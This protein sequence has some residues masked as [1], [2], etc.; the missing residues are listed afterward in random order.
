MDVIEQMAL[1]TKIAKVFTPSAPIDN[2]QLFAGRT[3]QLLKVVNAVSRRGQ[4][5][6]LYG[7]RGVGKTSLANILFEALENM[8]AGD[9][10]VKAVNCEA[11]ITFSSL[12]HNIFRKLTFKENAL[13]AGFKPATG[14]DQSADELLADTVSPDDVRFMF[15]QLAKPTVIIIDEV[16]RINDPEITTRLADTIKTLSDSSVDVTLV[17][18]GVA[19]SVDG[20]IAEHLSIER[21]LMQIQMPRMSAAELNEIMEKGLPKIDMTI[22]RDAKAQ[23][24][25]LSQGL[26]HYTHLLTLHAAQHAVTE[27]RRNIK[28]EDVQAATRLAVDQ[29][30]QSV[31][32]AYH[33][34]TISPRGNLYPQVL[35]SCALAPTDELGYFS[36]SEI[37]FPMSTI[38]GKPYDIPAFSRHLNDFCEAKRGPVLQ[39]T[40]FPK[41]YKFRFI[42]PLLGPYV[43]M[44]GLKRDLITDAKLETIRAHV[45]S[46]GIEPPV[47]QL[48]SVS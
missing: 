7:E 35:L 10:E 6:V 33:N 46:T 41:R 47:L 1:N 34:A 44:N 3:P 19:D 12:W 39:R 15:E 31:I 8:A 21:A 26:P 11:G 38:M 45:S 18:V 2:A 37:R 22:T 20:L 43:I 28:I 32:R 29:A 42:N 36:S 14:D 30:Q 9:Y 40:G 5:V 24:S 23:I 25:Q 17:L 16:D 27:D 13:R 4:H 48:D